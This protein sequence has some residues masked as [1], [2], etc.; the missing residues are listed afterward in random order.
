MQGFWRVLRAV[1]GDKPP[2]FFNPGCVLLMQDDLFGHANPTPPP[3]L[4]YR[5]KYL[6]AYRQNVK[7]APSHMRAGL[8]DEKIANFCEIHGFVEAEVRQ[9]IAE[10]PIVAACFA[11]DPQRQNFYESLAAEFIQG[12][13][14]VTAFE[15]LPSRALSV[16]N[17]GV[18]SR[19]QLLQSGGVPLAKTIDFAW[20]YRDKQFYA[21]HKHQRLEG[22]S[23][24]NQYQDL[25]IFISQSNPSK[26]ADTFFV[27]IAD[28]DYYGKPETRGGHSRLKE[29]QRL[30]DGQVVHACNINQLQAFMQHLC[31]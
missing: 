16:L 8:L 1:F 19:Q 4:D 20:R 5:Q 31:A 28:G 10:N 27:A 24:N 15:N 3:K 6:E 29:L 30:A 22:G 9:A 11:R 25:K 2:N 23:Q 14:G 13:S 12:L 7:Q 18:F 17:G 21:S 26:R